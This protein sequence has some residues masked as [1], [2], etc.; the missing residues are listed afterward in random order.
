MSFIYYTMHA[1]DTM[2]EMFSTAFNMEKG[3]LGLFFEMNI[4]TGVGVTFYTAYLLF[5]LEEPYFAA[6]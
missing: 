2:V 4:L 1:T 5:A 6:E 3:A